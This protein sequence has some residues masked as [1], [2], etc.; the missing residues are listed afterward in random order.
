MHH[1]GQADDER[2]ISPAAVA[3]IV[4]SGTVRTAEGAGVPGATVRITN[5]ET[6]KSWV[7]WTDET[8][9]FLIPGLPPGRYR[10]EASQ[11]GFVSATQELVIAG[12]PAPVVALSLRVAT[13]AEL[14]PPAEGSSSERTAA[15]N[16]NDATAPGARARNRPARPASGEGAA[17][18]GAPDGEGRRGQSPAGVTNAIRQGMGGFQQTDLTGESSGQGEETV[19]QQN[20]GGGGPQPTIAL[21]SGGGASSDAFLLQGTVGQGLSPNGPGGGGFG[22]PGGFG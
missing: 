16:P 15:T 9:K 2:A 17:A 10:M 5:V 19:A 7:S 20:G 6:N 8:G 12:P 1:A 3:A 13:L 4:V 21:S 14:N 18:S 22:G 11:L